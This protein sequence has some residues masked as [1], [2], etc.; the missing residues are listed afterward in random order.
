MKYGPNKRPHDI[1]GY[2]E[3]ESKSKCTGRAQDST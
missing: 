1:L 3:N 2:Y